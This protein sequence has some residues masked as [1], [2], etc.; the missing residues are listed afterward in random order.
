MIPK[1]ARGLIPPPPRARRAQHAKDLG[2]NTQEYLWVKQQILAASS[3]QMAEQ[4]GNAMAQ[5]FDKA[6]DDAKKAHDQ[7][8]DETTRKMY[9]D[10]MAGYA[11]TPSR[12]ARRRMQPGKRARTRAAHR[13]SSRSIPTDA[14]PNRTHPARTSR[15]GASRRT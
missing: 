12:V 14:G 15:K 9:A 4:F 10:V 6:Y 7:A 1:N 11:K 2:F 8:K 3:A 5:N 13:F